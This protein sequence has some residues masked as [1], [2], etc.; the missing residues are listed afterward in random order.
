MGRDTLKITSVDPDHSYGI[1]KLCNGNLKYFY[2]RW[3]KNDISLAEFYSAMKMMEP[4]TPKVEQ[5]VDMAYF[6]ALEDLNLTNDAISIMPS[7]DKLISD[8]AN[9]LAL[10]ESD[11]MHNPIQDICNRY[12]TSLKFYTYALDIVL[13]KIEKTKKSKLVG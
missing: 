7:I 11:P 9:D 10:A 6:Q 8:M 2:D 13:V 12:L 4:V 5:A 3:I 1:R